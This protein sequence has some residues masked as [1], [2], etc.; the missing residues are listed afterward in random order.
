ML[1]EIGRPASYEEVC[2]VLKETDP[3]RVEAVRRRLIA[4]SRDGQLIS[5][6]RDQFVP[7]KNRSDYWQ[8][9]GRADG[10]GFVLRDGG[11]RILST[12]QMSKVSWRS[13]R[14]AYC[15]YDRRGRPEGASKIL[16]RK[17]SAAGGALLRSRRCW[18]GS[19]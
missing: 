6:R 5:N 2:V 10:Y 7:S 16:E 19:A 9:A 12:R 13:R 14:G 11:R 17:H 18:P 8:G 3:E 1:E 4:M 15:G